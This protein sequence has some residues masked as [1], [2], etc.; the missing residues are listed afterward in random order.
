[1]KIFNVQPIIINEY[2]FNAEHLEKSKTHSSYESGF[3]I[4]GEQVESLNT[5]FVAFHILYCV[6]SINEKE[7]VTPVGPGKFTIEFSSTVG[8]GVFVSY[9]SSC[10][11]NFESEG[12]D[13]DVAS[14]TDFLSEYQEHTKSFFIQH[15]FKPLMQMEENARK[16]HP[17][18]A[19]AIIAIENLRENNMYEF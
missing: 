4:D 17:L 3:E 12:F 7:I 13:A 11:F 10:Q 8:D 18:K 16:Q 5:M 15:G 14:I 19:D 9:G 2:I 1:M 6:D